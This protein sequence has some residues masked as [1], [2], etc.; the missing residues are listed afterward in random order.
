[1][2]TIAAAVFGGAAGAE[3]SID[4]VVTDH[5]TQ[6]GI[7]VGAGASG[8]IGG[9]AAAISG[10]EADAYTNNNCPTVLS[11]AAPSAPP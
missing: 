6:V 3:G 10:M 1:M 9:V 2:L 5:N 4:A 7:A 8:V 11:Q